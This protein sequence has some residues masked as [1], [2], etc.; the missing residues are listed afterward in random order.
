[1]DA[2]ISH[3]APAEP[4]VTLENAGLNRGGRWLVRGIDLTVHRGEAVT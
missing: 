4:L 1:M 2:Q 3:T